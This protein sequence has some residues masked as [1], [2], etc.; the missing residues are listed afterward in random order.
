MRRVH[1]VSFVLLI[2]LTI[3]GFAQEKEPIDYVDVF[4]GTS[5]SRWM[6]GPYAGRPYGMVQ[7]GG[8]TRSFDHP[9]PEWD[10]LIK[11]RNTRTFA[12]S[13]EIGKKWSGGPFFPLH[14][15]ENEIYY[16]RFIPLRVLL[17]RQEVTGS[18]PVHPTN[19]KA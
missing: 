17:D 1:L 19:E 4:V 15:L 14:V 7:L 12:L 2:S 6:L 3:Q 11:Y 8:K 5:N 16:Y 13:T 18:I 9:S 10:K